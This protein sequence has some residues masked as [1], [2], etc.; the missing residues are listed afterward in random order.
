M[1]SQSDFPI[2]Q[3]SDAKEKSVAFQNEDTAHFVTFYFAEH[4]FGLPISEVVEINRSLEITPVPLAQ[5]YVAGIVN[6]R[7]QIITAVNLA[8][9]IEL[10]MNTE[11]V[12]EFEYH[13]VIL[14]RHN[15]PVSLLAER[16]GDVVEI[17]VS[18]IEPPPSLIEGMKV[19]YIKHVCKL[20][21]Q[22]LIILDG[23]S[24]QR[25]DT[26]DTGEPDTS[27]SPAVN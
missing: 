14:G 1:G 23:D 27:T 2:E 7:G 24:L 4:F 11:S 5:P 16:I 19:E 20:P 17:P 13:N 15:E 9:R 6:L 21:G 26:A 10:A 25:P 12:D 3:Q 8:R 22:L 18:Q